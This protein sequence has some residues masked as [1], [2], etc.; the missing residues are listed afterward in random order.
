MAGV[1][2]GLSLKPATQA[3]E[4]QACDPEYVGNKR[5]RQAVAFDEVAPAGIKPV[6]GQPAF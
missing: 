4:A 2:V 5:V 3:P 6:T 1:V